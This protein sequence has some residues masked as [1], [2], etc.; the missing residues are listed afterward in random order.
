MIDLDIEKYE[1]EEY[2]KYVEGKIK[3]D[4]NYEHSAHVFLDHRI[5]EVKI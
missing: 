2:Y 5:K 4:F 1:E 3:Q